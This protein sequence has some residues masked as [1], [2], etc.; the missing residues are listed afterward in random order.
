METLNR[1]NP[2]EPWRTVMIQ[3]ME[4]GYMDFAKNEAIVGRHQQPKI[5]VII[6]ELNR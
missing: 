4:M 3:L 5:D 6:D 2:N 1:K